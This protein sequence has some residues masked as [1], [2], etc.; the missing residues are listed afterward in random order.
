MGKATIIWT[1][2]PNE[3]GTAEDGKKVLRLSVFVSP[4]LQAESRSED[5]LDSFQDFLDWTKRMQSANFNVEF[6]SAA[7]TL[8]TI[9][10]LKSQVQL[11]EGDSDLW[12]ALFKDKTYVRSHTVDSYKN[13]RIISYP[14]FDLLQEL[15]L[16][17]QTIGANYGNR[18]LEPNTVLK[19]GPA[20]RFVGIGDFNLDLNLN[21]PIDVAPGGHNNPPD[22]TDPKIRLRSMLLRFQDFH[23]S[24]P[25]TQP[26]RLLTQTDLEN[27]I[28]FH[29]ALAS[30]SDYPYILRRLGIIFDLQIPIGDAPPINNELRV[31]VIPSWQ[32][33]NSNKYLSSTPQTIC[34]WDGKRFF[35]KSWKNEIDNGLVIL[36]DSNQPSSYELVE[37]DVDGATLKTLNLTNSLR[38]DLTTLQKSGYTAGLPSLRT[39][40]ISLVKTERAQSVKANLDRATEVSQQATQPFY[41]EDLTRGYRI[42]I[43]DSITKSWHSLCDRIGTYSFEQPGAGADQKGII[44]QGIPDEGYIQMAMTQKS[45]DADADLYL[46]ESLCRWEGWSLCVP[47]PGKSVSDPGVNLDTDQVNDPIT[48]FKLR[49]SFQPVKGSLPRLRFGKSYRLRARTVDLAGNSLLLKEAGDTQARPASTTEFT[50]RRFEPVDAPALVLRRPLSEEKTPGE[51]LERLVIRSFNDYAPANPA[52]DDRAEVDST[53]TQ[54]QCDRHVVPPRTSQQMAEVHGMFDVP[55]GGLKPDTYEL[56]A[57]KETGR[58]KT[59]QTS[60]ATSNNGM[61][62]EKELEMPIEPDAQI[63]ELPYFPDPLARGVAFRNLPATQT[64]TIGKLNS[65]G[66]LQY[67]QLPNVK[68][69]PGSATL[70]PFDIQG[71]WYN[72]LPFRVVLVEGNAAP[73]WNRDQRTLT[74][75]LPK[76]EMTTIQLSSYINPAD[77]KLMGIWQWLQEYIDGQATNSNPAAISALAE[78]VSGLVQGAIEGNH[79]M[80]TPYKEL[81]LVH[82]V[83]QPLNS[84]II[85]KIVARRRSG[86]TAAALDGEIKIHGKS[87]AKIEL[88]A[89]WEEPIDRIGE[90]EPR[91][92]STRMKACELLLTDLAQDQIKDAAGK[93]L[94]TY[95]TEE[96][97]IEFDDDYGFPVHAFEDTKYRQVRYQAVATSR[98]RE[99]FNPKQ[100]LN[101]C[102]DSEEIV[103]DVLATARPAAPKILYVVPTFGWERQTTTNL[104][105]SQR[106]GGGVRVYLDRPWYSSGEGELLG[107]VFAGQN[108]TANP[109]EQERLKPYVT[110]WGVD[111]IW[112]SSSTV[113]MPYT[114]NGLDSYLSK[115]VQTESGLSLNEVTG[116]TFVVAGHEVKY[117]RD[118]QLWYCDIQLDVVSSVSYFP[119]V[120]LALARYQPNAIAEAKL[121]PVILADFAQL[122]P[123]RSVILTYNPYN[124]D[125]LNVTVSGLTYKAIADTNGR[126]EE[127]GS[128]IEITV[129]QRIPNI[130]GDLGWTQQQKVAEQQAPGTGN[131]LWHGEVNLP[132]QR[133]PKEYRLVIKEFDALY[134]D[135]LP[136]RDGSRSAV[137]VKTKRLVYADAIEI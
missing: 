130:E 92:L 118:R 128:T 26:L 59:A 61:G 65:E 52:K 117:D 113:S 6:S 14:V 93:W 10:N 127:G 35:A 136:Q 43:W 126:R 102:R 48:P 135:P 37:V 44:I 95:D 125:R 98:F 80:L 55:T 16:K 121:S 129:E 11:G 15:K 112:E 34:V 131:L 1:A 115:T 114:A 86:E 88:M 83:Q 47:R 41:A 124:P 63:A 64:D 45:A 29:Q 66:N 111:P 101:F 105:M 85:E 110:Q 107:V 20:N 132:S 84:P 13:R 68:E 91:L 5:T 23:R 30:L 106:Q 25:T 108:M 60:Q 62:L 53:K 79:W 42:D 17:Y 123:D 57:K 81:V 4:R 109:T 87:T 94:G 137:A 75:A 49:T 72:A 38:R 28:D 33:S 103:V 96:D 18:L 77:L 12:K 70:I 90:P 22:L 78:R 46:H 67:T 27:Y 73:Q 116:A 99:Y 31:K 76:A 56:V 36:N 3:I 54:E 58:F 71:E 32:S 21:L 89:R 69:R 133:R 104:I 2:L 134:T 7:A 19:G 9:P 82:A 39:A 50:Y 119:F 40:G 122:A 120:R 74:V 51:S 24:P 97:L 8:K 100:P